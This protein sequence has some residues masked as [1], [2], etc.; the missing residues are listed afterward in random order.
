MSI[1]EAEERIGKEEAWHKKNNGKIRTGSTVSG[2]AMV[3][4]LI[5]GG[6]AGQE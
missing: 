5:A 4:G 1:E 6:S 2:A 3:G